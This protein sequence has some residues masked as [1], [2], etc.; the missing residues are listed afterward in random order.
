MAE[1]IQEKPDLCGVLEAQ[2]KKHF[3][4]GAGHSGVRSGSVSRG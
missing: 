3:N 2:R 1:K 4:E